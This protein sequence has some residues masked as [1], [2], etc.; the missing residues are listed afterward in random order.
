MATESRQQ[1]SVPPPAQ[2]HAFTAGEAARALGSELLTGL[3]AR[4]AAARLQRVGP[5]SMPVPPGRSIAATVAAQFR[6]PLIYLLVV[7]AALSLAL[8]HPGD[9]TVIAM[10]LA[11]NA[12]VGAMQEGRAQRALLALRSRITPSAR[13]VRDGNVTSTAAAQLVPGDVIVV[14]AGDAVPADAR[15]SDSAALQVTEAALT[16]ESMPVEKSADTLPADTPV[17]DRRNMLY[18]GTQL[19]AGRARGLVTATG[20]STEIGRIARLAEEASEPPTPLE[21]R[22]ASMAR[23]IALVA[24]GAS[25]LVAIAGLARRIPAGDIAMV[26][27]S[28]L[29]SA[30]P[31]GLP[32]A[33]TIAL[34]VAVQRMARRGAVIRHLGAVETLGSTTVICADKTGTLTRNEMTVTSIELS[35]G[36][37]FA[38]TGAGYDTRGAVCDSDGNPVTAAADPALFALLQAAVLCN[39]ARLAAEAGDRPTGDPTEI[40]LVVFAV[41][42]GLVPD[43]VRAEAPRRAELPFDTAVRMM[44]TAHALGE[45]NAV[46]LKGAPEVVI[47]LCA[48]MR[49]GDDA[50]PLGAS[51]RER[52]MAG[53]HRFASDGLRVLALASVEGGEIRDDTKLPDAFAGRATLLG[54][55]GEGD[56]PRPE[57]EGAIRTCQN[58]G[59]RVVM[60]TGDH[61]A[62][63]LA[64]ARTLGIASAGGAAIEGAALD[65]LSPEARAAR[66][67]KASVFARVHPE[68]KLDIV[69]ALQAH[70]EVVAMTGD[71]VNDAPALVAANVG[72]AMGHSGTDVAREA[73]D[74]V[75]SD[76]NFATIVAAIE[77]G[78]IAYG[79]IVKAIVLLM[80]TAVA[81][82]FILLGAMVLGMP[83]PFVAV[84][85]LWNNFVTEGLITVNLVMEP[86]EGSEMQRPP[87]P[88]GAPMLG[89]DTLRRVAMMATTILGVTLGWF[90]IRLA[91]GVPEAEARTEA[92]TLLA[93]CEWYNVLN[94][95][96]ATRSA[97]DPALFRNRWLIGGLI[98]GN[99]LQAA[100]VF[101]P[102]LQ[103]M[104]HTVALGPGVVVGLGVAGSTVL[105]VE[106]LRKWSTRRRVVRMVRA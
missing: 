21:R 65:S 4:E 23:P 22:I 96:S 61:G 89:R 2:W 106:E 31:E 90:A 46:M 84:Q 52:T 40:A 105:W 50:V 93:I 43:N 14:E 28:E 76:D 17:A 10:V 51:D 54:I 72:V 36:R 5:N 33:V 68:Q 34:V 35:D 20:M 30:I 66:I 59:I 41:K 27:I 3:T 98:A 71:G 29:V 99:A 81:E 69:A 37:T 1:I 11:I 8:G 101:W 63:G 97:L 12:A 49:A 60:L 70:N 44:A 85:I 86:G 32:V 75:I 16:G 79:N 45:R 25:A 56:P 104:F 57:V 64:V 100:V 18:A 26:A 87:T 88:V 53:V 67:A 6:S 74:M 39:D 73:A 62:T 42:A 19:T 24:V 47:P 91:A 55:V 94:C 9:A 7:A 92:F 80:S 58:A 82:V 38:V 83:L 48:T 77:E 102:P 103:R 15:L 13:V 78:R 95:R